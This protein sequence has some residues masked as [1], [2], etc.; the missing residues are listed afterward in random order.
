M[1]F[2][3]RHILPSSI[4]DQTKLGSLHQTKLD[5]DIQQ[6]HSASIL[7]LKSVSVLQSKFFQTFKA[8][9]RAATLGCP[10]EALLSLHT[11]LRPHSL[12]SMWWFL[13]G[14]SHPSYLSWT[15]WVQRPYFIHIFT[16]NKYLLSSFYVSGTVLPW[17]YCNTWNG[18][19]SPSPHQG[20]GH[21]WGG[22]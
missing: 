20:A 18:Q 2:R 10:N 8:Q 7:C 15:T 9:L 3:V 17:S 14:M 22:E 11:S 6:K 4:A 16:F 12:Q 13:T 21:S 19:T 5:S 1:A